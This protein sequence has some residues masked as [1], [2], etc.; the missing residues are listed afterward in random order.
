MQDLIPLREGLHIGL[1]GVAHLFACLAGLFLLG[2]RSVLRR[3][4]GQLALR[5]DFGLLR[6]HHLRHQRVLHIHRDIVRLRHLPV[7][8]HPAAQ[9]THFAIAAHKFA[10]R[11]EDRG[12]IRT[13]IITRHIVVIPLRENGLEQVLQV[14]ALIFLHLQLDLLLLADQVADAVG[15]HA[16]KGGL[17]DLLLQ[18]IDP[19][20]VEFAVEQEHVITLV[21]RLLDESVLLLGIGRIQIHHLAVLVGLVSFDRLAVLLEAEVLPFGILYEGKSHRALAEF[22]VG[23]H[24]ILD[25]ELEV[26]PLLL[27]GLPLILEDLLQPVGHLLGDVGR[28]LLYVGVAL[29]IAAGD[30]Q[31]NIRRVDDAVEQ[32]QEVRH[33]VIDMVGDKHLVAVER[34]LVALDR[35]PLFDLREIKNA[36]EGERIIDIQMNME[37]R[38]LLH[39]VEFAVE[40]VVVLILQLGRGLGPER[41]DV[42][43]DL[44]L[45]GIDILAVLPFLLL[46]EHDGNRHE[47]A[48]LVQEAFDAG[49]LAVFGGIVVQVQGDDRSA[50][51]LVNRLHLIGRG[52]VAGPFHRL[53]ALLPGKGLD[54]DLLRHHESAVKAQAEMADDAAD[55]VLVL[56]QELAGGGESDLVDVFVDLLLGHADAFVDDFQGLL[57]FVQFDPDLQVPELILAF[58]GGGQGL[59]LLGRID[60]VRHEL[61]EEDLVVGIQELLDDGENVLGGHTDLSFVCHIYYCL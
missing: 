61:P 53:R 43:D 16:R 39:R 14:I 13:K 15:I 57:L 59:E 58:A 1:M 44:V 28:N 54:G 52:A 31:R 20:A 7:E 5:G 12:L 25:E 47:L 4:C 6:G 30:I 35:H 17:L 21:L 8:I 60:G 27:Q 3:L 42:V 24:A 40:L 29:Q 22:L 38:L 33:N 36:R 45:V 23:Q 48:V 32:R 51:V 37:K 41:L 50:A 46:A 56:L 26:V 2:I 11:N 10:L 9:G 55:L 34:D 18:Q 19:V 49:L